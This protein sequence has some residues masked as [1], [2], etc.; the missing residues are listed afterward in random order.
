MALDSCDPP[1]SLDRYL[2][3][4]GDIAGGTARHGSRHHLRHCLQLAALKATRQFVS[5]PSHVRQW[6]IRVLRVSM[7]FL[8]A[9]VF[10]LMK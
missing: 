5:D 7:V 6:P 3:R 8:F 1:S 4:C 9:F 2:D 10:L